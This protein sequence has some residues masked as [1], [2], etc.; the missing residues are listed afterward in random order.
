MH[1]IVLHNSRVGNS[2]EMWKYQGGKA[3]QCDASVKQ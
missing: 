2:L 1:V 3:G